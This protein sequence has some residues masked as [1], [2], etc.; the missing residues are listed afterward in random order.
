MWSDYKHLSD[1]LDEDEV[2]FAIIVN[3]IQTI[4][5]QMGRKPL[6]YSEMDSVRKGIE[7]GLDFW[8]DIVKVAINNLPSE[9]EDLEDIEEDD[10]NE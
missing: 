2:V 7:L 5:E 8:Y 4:A 1:K 3:Y 10:D 6:N 9:D